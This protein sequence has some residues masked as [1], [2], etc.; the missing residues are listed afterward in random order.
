[1]SVA[2][3]NRKNSQRAYVFRFAPDTVA[4]VESC[5][6]PNFGETLKREENDDSDSLRRVSEVAY[7]FSM[8]R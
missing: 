4:K 7:E 6:S 1:M 5:I 3:Q 8:R 2:G